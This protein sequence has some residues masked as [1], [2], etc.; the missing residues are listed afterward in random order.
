MHVDHLVFAAGHEG[1]LATAERLSAALGE[2]S[3]DGGFHPRFG[4]RNRL[5]PLADDRYI[6]IVEVLE[7]PVADKAAF[8]QVVRARS[9]AGGGWLGWA[10]SVDDLSGF[11]RRLGRNSVDGSRHFPDGRLLEWK[12]IG[13]RG[14][15]ADPQLPFFIKW[16]SE[17]SVLPKALPG[18]V[19][20]IRLEIAGDRKRLEDWLG[21][22]SNMI[23]DLDFEIEWMAPHGTPGIVAAHFRT[24]AGEVRI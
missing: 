3:R 15:Q 21:C 1:L 5:I 6:E 23:G 14:T 20:L 19:D 24:A 11:E 22:K 17:E 16:T 18:S 7:H 10:I 4:T 13:V 9:E 2:P 8:G 12:Q